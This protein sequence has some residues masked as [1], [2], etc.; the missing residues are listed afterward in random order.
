MRRGK[1]DP[2]ALAQLNQ[3]L[4]TALDQPASERGRWMDQLGPEHAALKPRLQV[5]L[6]DATHREDLPSFGTLPKFDADLR[7]SP[8][9]LPVATSPG[10]RLGLTGCCGSSDAAGWESSG[11]PNAATGWSNV[12]SP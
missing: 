10:T 5:L 6:S 2:A 9:P 12:P 11:S 7:I 8:R 1:L 3:L 4:D